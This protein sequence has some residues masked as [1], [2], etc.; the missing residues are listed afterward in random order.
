MP[1]PRS[2]VGTLSES[3]KLP[4]SSERVE[5]SQQGPSPPVNHFWG[6]LPLSC[7][8]H[9]LPRSVVGTTAFWSCFF[10]GIFPFREKCLFLSN[11]QNSSKAGYLP[12][13]FLKRRMRLYILAFSCTTLN[14][15]RPSQFACPDQL[16]LEGFFFFFFFLA[17]EKVPETEGTCLRATFQ[18]KIIFPEDLKNDFAIFISF[19]AEKG[20]NVNL[21]SKFSK[22]SF[23]STLPKGI[24]VK[25]HLPL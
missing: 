19:I 14:N 21:S 13:T 8:D 12:L 22:A 7:C 25:L 23:S 18:A 4:L 16:G 17:G 1:V 10:L 24:K 2:E 9:T 5:A 3:R 11:G 6:Q 15:C 20:Q